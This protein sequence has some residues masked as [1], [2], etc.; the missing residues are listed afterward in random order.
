MS[1]RRPHAGFSLVELLMVVSLMGILAAL[2][3]PSLNPSLHDELQA[4][5]QIVAN[6]LNYGC[7]LAVANNSRYRFTFEPSRNRYVLEHAG[8]DSAL[9]ALPRTPFRSPSDPPNQHIF[10]LDDL[11]RLGHGV[12]LAAVGTSGST[13]TRV[14]QLTFDSLGASTPAEGTVVWL[15]AGSGGNTRYITVTVDPVTGLSWIGDF[16]AVPPAAGIVGTVTP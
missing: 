2:A 9:N 6:D 13:P 10:D 4:A 1:R 5:A 12:R 8:T 7:N 15:A 3:I 14:T 16:T 11:P